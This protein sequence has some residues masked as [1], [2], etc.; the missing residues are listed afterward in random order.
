MSSPIKTTAPFG[1]PRARRRVSRVPLADPGS[2]EGV[3]QRLPALRRQHGVED[4]RAIVKQA[5]SVLAPGGGAGAVSREDEED[6]LRD[7]EA[8][9][10]D[11]EPQ[12]R[13]TDG[14][15][16]P[17]PLFGQIRASPSYDA[18]YDKIL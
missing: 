1:S 12:W 14:D 7:V 3:L 6:V 18:R 9:M 13:I 11:G 2:L 5:A 17:V 16:P 10:G 15:Q 4:I 8:I